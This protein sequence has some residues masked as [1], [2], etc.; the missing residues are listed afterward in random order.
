MQKKYKTKDYKQICNFLA[1][2]EKENGKLYW[3]YVITFPVKK[4]SASPQKYS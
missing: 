2:T 1:Q 3:F 4:K